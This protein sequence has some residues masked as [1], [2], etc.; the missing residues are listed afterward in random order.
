M[1]HQRHRLTTAV[2]DDDKLI[3]NLL[4][5]ALRNNNVGSHSSQYNETIMRQNSCKIGQK[6]QSSV[7][8]GKLV[9]TAMQLSVA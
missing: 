4:N 2:D 7:F 8:S 9:V 6:V 3:T 5:V 1:Y